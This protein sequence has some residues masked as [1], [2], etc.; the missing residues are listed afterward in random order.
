MFEGSFERGRSRALRALVDHAL[1]RSRIVLCRCDAGV[2]AKTL[3]CPNQLAGRCIFTLGRQCAGASLE[4]GDDRVCV[5][6]F[7]QPCRGT[8]EVIQ[9]NK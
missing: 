6:R 8:Y 7:R 9:R 5:N 1:H 4:R 3:R 2:L